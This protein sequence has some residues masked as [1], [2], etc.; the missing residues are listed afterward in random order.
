[1]VTALDPTAMDM[2]AMVSMDNMHMYCVCRLM[3]GLSLSHLLGLTTHY[4]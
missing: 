2:T 4:I 3:L 1:M